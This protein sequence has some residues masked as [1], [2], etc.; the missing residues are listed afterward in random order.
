MNQIP[1]KDVFNVTL[2][3]DVLNCYIV[4]TFTRMSNIVYRGKVAMDEEKNIFMLMIMIL[5]LLVNQKFYR[6]VFT[7]CGRC[8]S[9]SAMLK[10]HHIC[11]QVSYWQFNILGLE[12]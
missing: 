5:L 6:F 12:I 3:K 11:F 10:T 8:L 7:P 9:I 1:T 4:I 2:I